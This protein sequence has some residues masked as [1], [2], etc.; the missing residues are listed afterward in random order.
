MDLEFY[1][2]VGSP[3]AYLAYRRLRQLQLSYPLNVIYMPML[4]GGVFKAAGSA[5]PVTIPAKGKYMMEHDLPRFA[6]RYGVPL[7]PNPFF[8]VNTLNLMRGVFA[9]RDLG[10][11]E[12]YIDTVYTAMWVDAKDMGNPQ[13]AAEVLSLAGLDAA[14]LLERCATAAIKEQLIVATQEAVARGVFGA[15]TLFMG[16][17]MYFGQDRLDF[18]EERLRA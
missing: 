7:T 18:V 16:Q 11:E 5:S 3:T 13:V 10:C 14:A 6:A 8:P 15:P 1:F 4:L 12:A 2:D 17:D 9:A